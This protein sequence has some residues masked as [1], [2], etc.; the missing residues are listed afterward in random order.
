MLNDDRRMQGA[1]ESWWYV[2]KDGLL[3]MAG[4]DGESARFPAGAWSFGGGGVWVSIE[5]KLRRERETE[6]E[7]LDQLAGYLDRLG[8]DEGWLVLFDLREGSTW[9][10]RL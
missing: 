7:A 2:R 10:E 8:L 4:F 6:E 5:V 3:D 9:Q 1:N